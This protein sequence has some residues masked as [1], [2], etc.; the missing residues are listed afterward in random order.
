M[1]RT[2]NGTLTV[3]NLVIHFVGTKEFYAVVY[4]DGKHVGEGF[5]R[6]NDIEALKNICVNI[7]C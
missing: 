2:I 1:E 4:R 3:K 7:Y 6:T 5:Y